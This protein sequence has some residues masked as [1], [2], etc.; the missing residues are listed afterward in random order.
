M[1]SSFLFSPSHPSPPPCFW[2]LPHPPHSSCCPVS[3]HSTQAGANPQWCR[4]SLVCLTLSFLPG[5]RQRQQSF[6]PSG[7]TGTYDKI[8]L[9]SQ[10]LVSE[11]EKTQKHGSHRAA[12]KTFL[13]PSE[14][15]P[16]QNP[17]DPSTWLR[18]ARG[19]FGRMCIWFCARY[20]GTVKIRFI[21]H[22]GWSV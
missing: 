6:P 12:P 9:L 21:Y 5:R 3:S 14:V 10:T 22:K 15:N 16:F 13:F 2:C 7:F 17:T 8:L 18:G 1:F 19:A 11:A 20:L 4:N